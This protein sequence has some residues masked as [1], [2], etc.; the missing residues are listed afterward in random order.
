MESLCIGSFFSHQN[1]S[2]VCANMLGNN[3][4]L[5]LILI[6]DLM[7]NLKMLN[8]FDLYW[9]KVLLTHEKT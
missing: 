9:K 3:A 5:L 6:L 2:L 7:R 1:K 8:I 4:I